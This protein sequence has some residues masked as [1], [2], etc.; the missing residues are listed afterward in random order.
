M[1]YESTRMESLPVA[2]AQAILSGIAPDGGLFVPMNEVT[3]N[4]KELEKLVDLSYQARAVFVLKQFLTD[5]NEEEL[6]ECVEDAYN[7]KNFDHASIA[8][9]TLLNDNLA[10]L[11][12]WHGPTYAFKD[13]ALQLLPVY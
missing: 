7:S 12:L 9:L 13:M 5:F 2:S 10:V 3:I 8:P 4:T 11:E 1:L 6:R